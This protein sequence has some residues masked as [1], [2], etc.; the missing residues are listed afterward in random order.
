MGFAIIDFFRKPSMAGG[1]SFLRD[2]VAIDRVAN[3]NYSRTL[4]K[5]YDAGD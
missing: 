4:V 3:V 5:M 1:N 2:I